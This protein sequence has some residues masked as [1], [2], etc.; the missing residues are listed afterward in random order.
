MSR[1][2]R[3]GLSQS[4]IIKE[5]GFVWKT[6]QLP[7]DGYLML[8]GRNAT[9]DGAKSRCVGL[10]IGSKENDYRFVIRRPTQTQEM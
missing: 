7:R 3:R 6:Q 8:S 5:F 1:Q 2:S 9:F 4:P 10:E